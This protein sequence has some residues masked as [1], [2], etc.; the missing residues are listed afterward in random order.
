MP[1]YDAFLLHVRAVDAGNA[2][3]AASGV[4]TRVEP[5]ALCTRAQLTRAETVALAALRASF[6]PD[7][8]PNATKHGTD[9][10]VHA[11]FTG[12]PC[13]GLDYASEQ[14]RLVHANVQPASML[15][16]GAR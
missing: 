4:K 16:P 9:E 13:R 7:T 5:G 2:A 14:A 15:M 8:P 11:A 10:A 1:A 6:A 12:E 3:E